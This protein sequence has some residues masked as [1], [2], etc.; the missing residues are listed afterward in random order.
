MI[1]HPEVTPAP[2]H[3]AQILSLSQTPCHPTSPPTPIHI[4][5]GITGLLIVTIALKNTVLVR[6]KVVF[7]SPEWRFPLTGHPPV[8]VGVVVIVVRVWKETRDDG[9]GL[10]RS[11]TSTLSLLIC[12]N[13]KDVCGWGG[14]TSKVMCWLAEVYVIEY[15]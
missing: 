10:S 13:V 4:S 3:L 5:S 12:V 9:V 7:G 6:I 14:E 2:L 8:G 1:L 11:R 15:V